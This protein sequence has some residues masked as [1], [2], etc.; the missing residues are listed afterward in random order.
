VAHLARARGG[1]ELAKPRARSMTT[2]V[3]HVDYLSLMRIRSTRRAPFR[4]LLT[5]L[6]TLF[7]ASGPTE[8]AAGNCRRLDGEGQRATQRWANDSTKKY[9]RCDG[10][11]KFLRRVLD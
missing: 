3:D 7:D 1:G 10:D 9:R 4:G 11:E 8:N 6:Q 2:A 5:H